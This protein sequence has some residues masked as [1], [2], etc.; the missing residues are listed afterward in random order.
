MTWQ[1]WMPVIMQHTCI[2]QK[3]YGVR[4]MDREW[5]LLTLDMN[6]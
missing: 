1:V 6:W 5:Q 4:V 2:K 3:P